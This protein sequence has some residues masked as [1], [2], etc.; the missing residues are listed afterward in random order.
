MLAHVVSLYVSFRRRIFEICA[1]HICGVGPIARSGAARGIPP[2]VVNPPRMKISPPMRGKAG[3][4][5]DPET[6]RHQSIINIDTTRKPVRKNAGIKGSG[7]FEPK[8]LLF[9]FVSCEL[10]SEPPE[11]EEEPAE[12]V[13]VNVWRAMRTRPLS[14]SCAEEAREVGRCLQDRNSDKSL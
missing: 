5:G 3:P 7:P 2:N 8:R 6:R 14:S 12:A 4:P 13:V 10:V 11:A 9:A 1:S